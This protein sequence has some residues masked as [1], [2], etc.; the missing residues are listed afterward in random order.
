MTKRGKAPWGPVAGIVA[1]ILAIV[2]LGVL[3]LSG[4]SIDILQPAGVIASQQKD[5]L[6][7]TVVLTM[8]A[9]VPVFILLFMAA[10]KFREGN[11]KKTKYSPD[12]EGNRT[13]E[14]IWW[15]I[16]LTIITILG[17]V[18]WVTTHQLD[19][20][21]EL[22]NGK[23]P[24]RVQVISLDWKWLF[25]YPDQGIA[26]VNELYIPVNRPINFTLTADS[27]M[28]AMWIPK[29]GSQIYVM[30]GMS[31]KL[32]LMSSETGV[33]KGSNTNITGKGYS[34]MYFKVHSV[35]ESS[36]QDW[37]KKAEKAEPLNYK[38]YQ[39]LAK[40]SRN[41]G[42]KLFALEDKELFDKVV[43][44]YVSSSGMD[45]NTDSN[46]EARKGSH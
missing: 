12:D 46:Y 10:W 13:L 14:L 27:P 38:Q 40:P 45:H 37:I 23:E 1:V 30:K 16:P 4:K 39:E 43:M 7:F 31:T 8:F 6:I 3:L 29:L 24:V 33:F 11:P 25:I 18:T 17:I 19:P 34:D 26:S 44:K 20:F 35:N 15:G 42:I 9:V 21:R 5:L 41:I 22:D 32:S 28:S 2:V 36:W